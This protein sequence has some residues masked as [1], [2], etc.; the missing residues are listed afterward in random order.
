M[1]AILLR[2]YAAIRYRMSAP[3]RAEVDRASATHYPEGPRKHY[4]IRQSWGDRV[5][6][7]TYPDSVTGNQAIPPMPG[8]YL[9]APLR[10]GRTGV[11]R[12]RTV[13]RKADP[14]DYFF[15]EVDALGYDLGDGRVEVRR[16]DEVVRIDAI[17][18]DTRR[19]VFLV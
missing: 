5:S 7:L 11:F 13:E 6:W 4:R 12:F 19:V 3:F 15:A 16:G 1:T 10:S 9:F 17:E 14:P 2:L 18:P 8:D